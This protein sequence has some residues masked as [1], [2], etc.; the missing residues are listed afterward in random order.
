MKKLLFVL[1]LLT[2]IGCGKEYPVKPI[3]VYKDAVVIQRG[4]NF[5]TSYEPL[6]RLKTKDSIFWVKVVE[7]DGDRFNIGDTIK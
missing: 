2:F 3:E 5:D 7:Y 6:I 1:L 4:S